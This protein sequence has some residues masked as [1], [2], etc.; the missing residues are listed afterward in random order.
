VVKPVRKNIIPL[1]KNSSTLFFLQNIRDE[2]H[3]FAISYFRNLHGKTGLKSG[4]EEIQGIGG[5]KRKKLLMA[6]KNITEIKKAEI[7]ALEKIK[8]ISENDAQRIYQFFHPL[9]SA[10]MTKLHDPD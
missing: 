2:A 4:L 5:V 10:E 6:F 7:A 1:K 3:R 9:Q 8:G